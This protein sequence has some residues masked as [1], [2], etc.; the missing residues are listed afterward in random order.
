MNRDARP[1]PGP[2]AVAYGWYGEGQDPQTFV[3]TRIVFGHVFR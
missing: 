1:H 2:D 3:R